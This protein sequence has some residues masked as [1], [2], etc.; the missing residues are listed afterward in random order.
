MSLPQVRK[1]INSA[2]AA[3]PQVVSPACVNKRCF[4]SEVIAGEDF[5]VMA[6]ETRLTYRDLAI[7]SRYVPESAILKAVFS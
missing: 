4:D 1:R 3:A 6:G 2:K 5:V 7:E